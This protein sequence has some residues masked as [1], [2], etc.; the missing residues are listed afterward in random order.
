MAADREEIL[1]SSGKTLEDLRGPQKRISRLLRFYPEA[2]V[3]ML[4][5]RIAIPLTI[6]YG[7]ITL[8]YFLFPGTGPVLKILT[9]V[10]WAL[11]TP[12]LFAVAKGL[13]LAWTRGMAFGHL[14]AEFAALYRK[15]YAKRS[16]IFLAFP[17]AA[18]TLWAA[19][20]VLLILRW[21][22]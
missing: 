2:Y 11:W 21:R 4:F 17:Y 8:F 1:M 6:L 7:P 16:G 15:R 19:G 14:N 18:T 13:S 22:P 3:H 20:F 12:Q 5:Y 10:L 9:A